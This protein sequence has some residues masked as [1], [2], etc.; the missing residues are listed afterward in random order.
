MPRELLL[1]PVAFIN[2]Y[3][4]VIDCSAFRIKKLLIACISTSCFGGKLDV[5]Q[6]LHITGEDCK[7]QA[8][9]AVR[10][11]LPHCALATRRQRYPRCP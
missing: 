5:A 11:L 10:A 7:K 6:E 2:E 9:H 4:V 8:L 3:T 1:L